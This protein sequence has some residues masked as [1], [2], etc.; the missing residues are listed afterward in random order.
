M[1]NKKEYDKINHKG[2]NDENRSTDD[3]ELLKL[4]TLISKR[5]IY[6]IEK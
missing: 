1:I 6:N 3:I 4:G 5:Y 2:E